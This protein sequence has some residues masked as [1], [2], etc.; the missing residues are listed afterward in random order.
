[1]KT[2]V[3]ALIPLKPGDLVSQNPF[4]PPV[5]EGYREETDDEFRQRLLAGMPPPLSLREIVES[6][7]HPSRFTI[8][9]ERTTPLVANILCPD[10]SE[11]EMCEIAGRVPVVWCVTINGR[12]A[13]SFW[14]KKPAP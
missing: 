14:Q 12:A 7:L 8:E 9:D 5:S 2:F 3:R 4:G 13:S 1:M 11:K 6:V 10:A